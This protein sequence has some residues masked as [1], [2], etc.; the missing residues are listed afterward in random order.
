[1]GQK[2]SKAP[3]KPENRK[4]HVGAHSVRPQTKGRIRVF[5]TSQVFGRQRAHT[6][7]PYMGFALLE[8]PA[9]TKGFLQKF[10]KT[11]CK[12]RRYLVYYT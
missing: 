5:D 10:T 7:R 1:M 8:I 6:V 9:V 12:T 3:D 2:F 11:S 4:I